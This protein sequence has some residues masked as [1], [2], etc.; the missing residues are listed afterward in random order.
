MQLALVFMPAYA[1]HLAS[2]EA[3]ALQ[4]HHAPRGCKK[5]GRDEGGK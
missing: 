3:A 4:G 5:A 2:R 1:I